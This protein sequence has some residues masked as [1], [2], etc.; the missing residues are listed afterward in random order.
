VLLMFCAKCGDVFALKS[1]NLH[2]TLIVTLA[3][4]AAIF[5]AP[6]GKSTAFAADGGFVPGPVVK[7]GDYTYYCADPSVVGVSRLDWDILWRVRDKEGSSPEKVYTARANEAAHNGEVVPSFLSPFL[8][9][10]KLW[11]FEAEEALKDE[12][13]RYYRF[14]LRCLD[15]KT[16]DVE[17]VPLSE[18]NIFFVGEDPF[19]DRD[20]PGTMK[21]TVSREFSYTLHAIDAIGAEGDTLYCSVQ[22]GGDLYYILAID[23]KTGTVTQV[24][25]DLHEPDVRVVPIG[26]YRGNFYYGRWHLRVENPQFAVCAQKADA[27]LLKKNETTL[28]DGKEI[29]RS[30]SGGHQFWRL[31]RMPRKLPLLRDGAAFLYLNVPPLLLRFSAEEGR[32]ET[33]ADADY[34]AYNPVHRRDAVFWALSNRAGWTGTEIM[35][36]GKDKQ[37]SVLKDENAVDILIGATDRHIYYLSKGSS[38]NEVA[39][40]RLDYKMGNAHPELLN[41]LTSR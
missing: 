39:V 35:M 2:R 12:S 14:F 38:S 6:E 28:T 5:V 41:K 8:W 37:R 27:V 30:M 10:G 22:D 23:I 3:F 34:L 9:R 16:L 33:V 7:L 26:I 31:L 40:Y 19:Y 18:E 13:I 25:A 1:K 4:V 24:D 15:E 36:Y 20:M 21:S 29:M 11:F 32:L 17:G